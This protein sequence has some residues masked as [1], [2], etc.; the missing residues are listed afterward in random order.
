MAF[1]NKILSKLGLTP[2]KPKIKPGK[3]EIHL[4]FSRSGDDKRS[5]D[6]IQP[7]SQAKKTMVGIQAD[8]PLGD[9]PTK[10]SSGDPLSCPECQYPLRVQ[11]S[12]SSPCPNCGFLGSRGNKEDTVYD[13]GKT[14]AVSSLDTTN[15]PGIQEFK[16]KL[17]EESSNSEIKIES[18]DPEVILNR[19]HLDPNNM[20]ISGEQHVLIKFRLNKIFI[21]DA[22]S[23]GSTFIQVKNIMMIQP[24]IR[25]ILGNKICLFNLLDPTLK[26]PDA[27]KA[28]RKFGGFDLNVQEGASGFALVDEK[29]GKRIEFIEQ[30]VI[31]NRANLDTGNNTISGSRHAEFHFENGCWYL[32]DLSST[33]A[34]FVQVKTEYQLENKMKLV[35][36]N[37]VF[38]FEYDF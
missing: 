17:I 38:R 9:H 7:D 34:T 36:G 3:S 19:S 2:K 16:F 22:S 24:G 32:K 14:V 27:D 31:V 18:E 37:K 35:I 26:S 25:L 33:G 30:H 21:E 1:M 12:K 23:N 6:R 15:D 13:P 10:S 8:R 29:S 4:P 20:S 11:P 28:T 5:H